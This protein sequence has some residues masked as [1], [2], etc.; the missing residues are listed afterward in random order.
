[1]TKTVEKIAAEIKSL[2][3]EEYEEFLSWLADY[4]MEHPDRWDREI[5][6]DSQPGA[7][8]DAVLKRVEKDIAEGRVKPLDEVVDDS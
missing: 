2:P 8:L 4:E 1:M 3:A 6:R 5:A 7:A